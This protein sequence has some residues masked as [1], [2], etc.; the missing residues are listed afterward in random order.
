MLEDKADLLNEESRIVYS[1]QSRSLQIVLFPEL[2]ETI[3]W[4][5]MDPITITTF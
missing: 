4:K 1:N 2:N 3:F 5:F